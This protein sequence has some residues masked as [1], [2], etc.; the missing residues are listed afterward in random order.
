MCINEWQ[1]ESNIPDG[2]EYKLWI[3][4]TVNNLNTLR[5]DNDWLNS[6]IGQFR[7]SLTQFADTIASGCRYIRVITI[8]NG[9]WKLG[10]Y[11]YIKWRYE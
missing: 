5:S 1:S 11:C 6:T 8:N 4:L 10:N 9:I 3:P 2:K 7:S